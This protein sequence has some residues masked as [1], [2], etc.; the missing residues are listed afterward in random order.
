MDVSSWSR[1]QA[2]TVV[3]RSQCRVIAGGA[4]VGLCLEP[5]L[6][7]LLCVLELMISRF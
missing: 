7:L 5:T 6:P 3:P 1:Q 4:G 2:G